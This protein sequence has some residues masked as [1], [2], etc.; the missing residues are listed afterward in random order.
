MSKLFKNKIDINSGKIYSIKD[1]SKEIMTCINNNGYYTGMIKDCYGNKY[2]GAHEVIYAE[3]HQLPKH[4]W[5]NN[6]INHKDENK[7][8]NS[9]D[10]LELKD[11][12]YNNTYNERHI[13]IGK[14]LHNRED[15]S[16]TVYKYTLDGKLVE[17][18]PSA[19]EA[20]R[21]NNVPVPR[22]I[23][24]CNGGWFNKKYNKW[25]NLTVKGYKY[26]YEHS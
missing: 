11:R 20:S 5:G 24:C 21:Q 2:R 16:K 22:I 18:Y 12:S 23:Q 4:L 25:C 3:A 6:Q 8:N 7:S 10:N 9:I 26:S 15:M 1:N 14:K 13:K 17:I 19:S